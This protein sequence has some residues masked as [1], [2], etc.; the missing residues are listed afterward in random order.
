ME[1]SIISRLV[2]FG[3]A[4]VL[5]ALAQTQS[6]A[7]PIPA[8]KVTDLGVGYADL[9][10]DSKGNYSITSPDKQTTIAFPITNYTT[11]D[12]ALINALPPLTN[13]PTD[14][15]PNH[16][17]SYYDSVYDLKN[18]TV[19]AGNTY[20]ISGHIKDAGSIVFLGH[21]QADGSFAPLT[22]ILSST[23]NGMNG[24]G[25]GAFVVGISAGDQVLLSRSDPLGGQNHYS[26]FDVQT[27]KST[28]LYTLLHEAG[29]P[30]IGWITRTAISADGRIF[31]WGDV[32]SSTNP[33]LEIGH[34]FI[35]TPTALSPAPV[36]EPTV[37]AT[38]IMGV[39]VLAANRRNW[40]GVRSSY[41]KS[42]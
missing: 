29:A 22:P 33:A 39:A 16:T 34:S 24:T 27:M 26:L 18:G 11:N 8:Y 38:F 7:S 35:L 4:T 1:R 32:V 13:R 14:E 6:L 15:S 12:P 21:R 3:S 10:P 19:I 25:S 36:P 23:A 20:G 31:L 40:L 42:P 41:S 5:I 17:F 2:C 28:D 9:S 37:L 30:N